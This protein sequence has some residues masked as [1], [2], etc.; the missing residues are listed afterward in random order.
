ML[1]LLLAMFLLL[2]EP[3]G[4][5]SATS[6]STGRCFCCSKTLFFCF[7]NHRTLFVLLPDAVS[8]ASGATG[9]YVP[10]DVVVMLQKL[11]VLLLDAIAAA[12]AGTGSCFC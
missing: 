7:P 1:L 4:D 8:D 11:V 6:Y 2:P 3:Q 10:H 9:R 12:S 5:V